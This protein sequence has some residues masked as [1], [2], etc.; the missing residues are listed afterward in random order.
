ML[1]KILCL[2]DYT[3]P[4]PLNIFHL[5]LSSTSSSSSSSSWPVSSRLR[6]LYPFFFMTRLPFPLLAPVHHT[7][8]S[9]H[10][11]PVYVSS[12]SFSSHS[13]MTATLNR[14]FIFTS[15]PW[16]HKAPSRS[17][18]TLKKIKKKNLV[19]S[20][21]WVFIETGCVQRIHRDHVLSENLFR[22]VL[23]AYVHSS[24]HEANKLTPKKKKERTTEM[25]CEP[26]A[27]YI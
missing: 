4:F 19:L 10:H 2:V 23:H 22:S 3:W 5:P 6:L 8:A 16:W 17:P 9:S 27:P 1:L 24:V 15:A 20:P 18:P 13:S 25:Q 7:V 12:S 21:L 26:T 11:S 14:M